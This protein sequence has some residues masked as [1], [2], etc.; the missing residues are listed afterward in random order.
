LNYCLH[1][2]QV[3]SHRNSMSTSTKASKHFQLIVYRVIRV[4][5]TRGPQ[6]FCQIINEEE[7]QNIKCHRC[8]FTE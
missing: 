1:V 8:I 7:S 2:F 5:S 4:D 3:H 6:L